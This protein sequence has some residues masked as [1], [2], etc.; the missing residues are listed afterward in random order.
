VKLGRQNK[1]GVWGLPYGSHLLQ[2]NEQVSHRVGFAHDTDGQTR[3]KRTLDP[4]DQ[5]GPPEAVDTEIS[6]EPAGQRDI[7]GG[8]PWSMKL[9][10]KIRYD[11][12]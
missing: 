6:I 1:T 5:F 7:Q 9:M 12:N 10:D 2:R 8:R 4:Y 11:S 3:S